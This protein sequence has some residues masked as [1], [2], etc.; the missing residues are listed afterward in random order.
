[1]TKQ[2]LYVGDNKGII[3]T[4]Q[5]SYNH[6]VFFE[7]LVNYNNFTFDLVMHE[8]YIL[9]CTFL[10]EIQ[11]IIS[12]HRVQMHFLCTFEWF[13]LSNL[14]L[15]LTKDLWGPTTIAFFFHTW[16]HSSLQ[17]I[18]WQTNHHFLT[19]HDKAI[20]FMFLNFSSI[21]FLLTF[22]CYNTINNHL[23]CRKSPF[24]NFDDFIDVFGC[25]ILSNGI[26]IL[27]G[28]EVFYKVNSN[29][30]FWYAISN[31]SIYTALKNAN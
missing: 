5:I 1:L 20:K 27:Q 11:N 14:I 24:C 30:N 17:D 26:L 16:G 3:L 7:F 29:S 6:I 15:Q 21:C 22:N 18:V 25:F 23:D 10:I 31:P 13:G 28:E 4:P 8:I 19:N 12:S 9:E 2:W